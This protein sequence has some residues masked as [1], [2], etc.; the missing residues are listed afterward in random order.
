[1]ENTVKISAGVRP[2]RKNISI[3]AFGKVPS[4][5]SFPAL[6]E[7]S[8]FMQIDRTRQCSKLLFTRA[9]QIKRC[10]CEPVRLS[11]VAIPRLEGK[12]TEKCPEEWK[13]LRF[14]VVIVSWFRSTGGLPHQSADWFAMTDNLERLV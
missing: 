13:S 12:C 10:H 7:I 14:L 3:F 9:R 2:G 11:G 5:N 4:K 8:V 6:P 1:M